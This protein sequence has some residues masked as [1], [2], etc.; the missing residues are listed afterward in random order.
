MNLLK[1]S[2]NLLS[3]LTST[4]SK[5]GKKISYLKERKIRRGRRRGK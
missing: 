1:A 4:S 5:L 2:I 3:S